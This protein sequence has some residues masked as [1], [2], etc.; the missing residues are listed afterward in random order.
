MTSTISMP[1]RYI[2][3]L[4]ASAFFSSGEASQTNNLSRRSPLSSASSSE[5]AARIRSSVL[6]SKIRSRPSLFENSSML[7]TYKLKVSAKAA[8][9]ASGKAS[10]P[11]RYSLYAVSWR[12]IPNVELM[13]ATR[14]AS[15]LMPPPPRSCTS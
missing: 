2:I 6:R 13:L 12:C 1:T 15:S 14:L 8:S 7:R 5:R 10:R 3:Y 4:F 11:A 9:S